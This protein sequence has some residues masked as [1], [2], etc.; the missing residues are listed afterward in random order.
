MIDLKLVHV[1]KDVSAYPSQWHY[2]ITA[3]SKTETVLIVS[4]FHLSY[5]CAV[6]GFSKRSD[7][8]FGDNGID[9]VEKQTV[10]NLMKNKKSLERIFEVIFE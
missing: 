3:I 7:F 8:E 2:A 4:K 1:G 10:E 9:S 6:Y 5:H